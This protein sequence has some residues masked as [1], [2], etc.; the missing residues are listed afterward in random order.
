MKGKNGSQFLKVFY[1]IC[2]QNAVSQN[3][4]LAFPKSSRSI[5]TLNI[6]TT[7]H[8][9]LKAAFHRATDVT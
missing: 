9:V 4:L 3:F 5:S 8:S 6:C 7:M 2:V 1:P